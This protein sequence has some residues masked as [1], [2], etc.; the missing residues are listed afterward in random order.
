MLYF[1]KNGHYMKLL[2]SKKFNK[3]Y[4]ARIVHI[5]SFEQ[6]P[7]PKCTRMKC[8]LVGGFSISVSLDTE[9]GWFIYFPVGSQIDGSYL[10]AMNLFRKAP[11]NTDQ[12]KTGFFE[13]NRKV[14][15]IKLQGYPSEGFL[16]PYESLK[17]W[18]KEEVPEPKE[19]LD[20]DQVNETVL[21]KRYFVR[22]QRIQGMRAPRGKDMSKRHSKL[23][24]GQFRLHYETDSL[25]RSPWVIKPWNLI[26]CS[27]KFHGTSAVFANVLCHK[28]ESKRASVG[29][30]IANHILNPLFGTDIGLA[31]KH[32]TYD[33]VYSSRKVVK[34]EY[35]NEQVNGGYYNCDV[36]GEANKIIAPKLDKGITVYAEIVGFLPTGQAIQSIGGIPYDYGCVELK[37]NEP[38][39]YGKHYDI[40]IYRVTFTNCEGIV[41]EFS[42]HE[43]QIWCKQHELHA[44][45][46]LYWG[47]AKDLYPDLD[48][49]ADDWA[50]QFCRKLKEDKDKFFME[51]NSPDCLNIVPHEGIVVKIDDGKQAAY[52]VKSQLFL[53]KEDGDYD[54]GIVNIEDAELAEEDA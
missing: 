5:T 33:N 34:N 36:W 27:T 13:D 23:V 47:F 54:K 41:H 42:A 31:D 49:H 22:Q 16:M 25:E 43:V 19:N 45:K 21:V 37:P 3:E 14:K 20:F 17:Y 4:C 50:T 29:Y 6:H 30:W 52:K 9:P 40:L 12:T 53:R 44:V 39:T 1:L 24:E 38:Y 48:I 28:S 35:Y 26:H 46:E 10:S 11:M 7:N 8:A 15:P 32:L 51:L 18:L 2:Q